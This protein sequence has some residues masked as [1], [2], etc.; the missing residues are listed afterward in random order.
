MRNN[1]AER[2]LR[3]LLARVCVGVSVLFLCVQLPSSTHLAAA[4][5]PAVRTVRSVRTLT[6]SRTTATTSLLDSSTHSA[7]AGVGTIDA[8]TTTATATTATAAAQTL[9]ELFPALARSLKLLG[10]SAPT[11]IQAAA[12]QALRQGDDIAHD[13]DDDDINHVSNNNHQ[14]LMLIAPTGSGKTLAYLLPAVTKV[15]GDPADGNAQSGGGTLLMVAPTRELAV[16]LRRDTMALLAP[17]LGDE[18]NENDEKKDEIVA[19]A[20]K[21]VTWPTP[22][23]LKKAVALIGTPDELLGVLTTLPGSLDFLRSV[24]ALVLDEVDVLLPLPPKMLR[25]SLDIA[26]GDKRHNKNNK[27]S[28]N[29]P[30]EERRIQEQRRKFMA[31]KRGGTEINKNKQLVSPTERIVNMVASSAETTTTQDAPP[32]QVLAGS[33]TASRKTLERLQRMLRAAAVQE[34]SSTVA[35]VWGGDISVCRPPETILELLPVETTT[36]QDPTDGTADTEDA[37]LAPPQSQQHTI[38]AV[39][40]PAQVKHAFVALPKNE[41][42]SSDAI[43]ATVAK[44][45]VQQQQQSTDDA[46]KTSLLFICGEFGKAKQAAA[47]KSKENTPW[48]RSN[49]AAH[50][51]QRMASQ[52]ANTNTAKAVLTA[53]EACKKLATHGIEA[54]PLHVALGLG[55][56]A[57]NDDNGEN[58][59][60]AAGL[61]PI[62]VTFEEAARG[63]HLEG[64]DCVYVVGRPASAASYL[65]VAGRVGRSAPSANGEVVVRPGTVVSICTKGSAKELAKWTKQVGAAQ[66][67]EEIVLK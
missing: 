55:K 52:V 27:K 56:G 28:N 42:A 10:F 32:V 23:E 2:G 49:A 43:L 19:L 40:V 64:I 37:G 60:T 35:R 30:K 14:N 20:I 17:L 41:A 61:P 47:A 1:T 63:L 29:S 46:P 7:D 65:H 44:L 5:S 3:A 66:L 25:T 24:R 54:Q 39:S 6:R 12:A 21:G 51:K 36:Q 33:A 13:N 11:P 50:K 4:F 16:Q 31:A 38:R 34:A 59:S 57:S 45:V 62:L 26:K 48:T 67:L 18:A 53:A 22:G 8:A 58:G 15:M 9:P